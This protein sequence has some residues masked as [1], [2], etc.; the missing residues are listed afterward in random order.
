MTTQSSQALSE[1]TT[2]VAN[3]PILFRKCQVLFFKRTKIVFALR[4]TTRNE[5]TDQ[6]QSKT[7]IRIQTKKV[8]HKPKSE[9][10]GEGEAE[11]GGEDEE[12][13]QHQLPP[14]LSRAGIVEEHISAESTGEERAAASGARREDTGSN[15][16][17]K[18]GKVERRMASLDLHYAGPDIVGSW[19]V[20]FVQG[21]LSADLVKR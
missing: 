10:E 8:I 6:N 21:G 17:G 18:E 12:N 7:K 14:G 16:G 9:H 20:Q 11:A 1:T 2:F 13:E 3:T 4:N 19:A 15:M 5:N